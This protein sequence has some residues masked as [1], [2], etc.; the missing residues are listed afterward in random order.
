MI[1]GD[2]NWVPKTPPPEIMVVAYFGKDQYD[3][4]IYDFA[5]I[6]ETGWWWVDGELVPANKVQAWFSIAQPRIN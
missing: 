4:P 1:P 6:D 2:W 3:K 5:E